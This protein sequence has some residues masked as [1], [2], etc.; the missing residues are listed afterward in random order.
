M[1]ILT[2]GYQLFQ[3]ANNTSVMADIDTAQRGVASGMLN[4]ARNLGL[5]SGA[6]VMGA[7]YALASSTADVA[8]SRPES[9]TFG[10]QATFASA[11]ALVVV[12]LVLVRVAR[13]LA[14]R[15]S[16]RQEAR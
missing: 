14:P 16:S 3:T 2:P 6:S 7:I 15:S 10:M 5:I 12:A 13:A 1:A 4:L 8:T 9:V 11:T